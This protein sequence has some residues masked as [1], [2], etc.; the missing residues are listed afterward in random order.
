MYSVS[1]IVCTYNQEQTIGRTLDAIL[2]QRSSVPFEVIIGDDASTDG[3]LSVCRTYAGKYPDKVRLLAWQEN[4][5]VLDNYY[6]CVREAHGEF[7]MECGGDDEWCQ[8]RMELCLSIMEQHP[9]VV[10]V[11]TDVFFRSER[12]GEVRPSG[13]AI[14]QPGV[15]KGEEMLRILFRQK[16][17]EMTSFAMTRRAAM[18]EVMNEFPQFFS[19]RAYPCEDKQLKT[20]VATKGDIFFSPECT[21]YYNIDRPSITHT[22]NQARKFYYAADMIRLNHDLAAALHYPESKL[23]YQDR[24]FLKLML[25]RALLAGPSMKLLLEALRWCRKLILLRLPYY[26]KCESSDKGDD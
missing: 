26:R 22:P 12:T 19:G 23:R 24:H 17:S 5:G 1:V 7:I 16:A 10:Q 18:I 3:T 13:R 11:F 15:T 9:E 20:L 25:R 2:S 6:S 14:L 21:Y 4:R 8:G